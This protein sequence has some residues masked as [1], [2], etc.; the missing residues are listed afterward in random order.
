M[1]NLRILPRTE[2][3]YSTPTSTYWLWQTISGQ[4]SLFFRVSALN[5]KDFLATYGHLVLLTSTKACLKYISLRFFFF[6]F[7]CKDLMAAS[8]PLKQFS[9]AAQKVAHLTSGPEMHVTRILWQEI[10]VW[11]HVLMPEAFMFCHLGPW[12]WKRILEC[13]N[14]KEIFQK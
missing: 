11:S 3:P 9:Q 1:E 4:V 5:Q 14:F 12:G 2:D 6:F 8:V 13:Q 7:K 10:N